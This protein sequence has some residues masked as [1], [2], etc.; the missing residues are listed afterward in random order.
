MFDVTFINGSAVLN[1]R[2]TDSAFDPKGK[3]I[4]N[5]LIGR[6]KDRNRLENGVI[7]ILKSK[8]VLM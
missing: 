7:N 2:N 8:M 6:G 4:I 3:R 5:V 1:I